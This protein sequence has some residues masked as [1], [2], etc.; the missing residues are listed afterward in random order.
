MLSHL[1]EGYNKSAKKAFGLKVR[2]RKKGVSLPKD[3]VSKIQ[4]KNYLSRALHNASSS[5]TP[6][7][8]QKLQLDLDVLK[9]EIRDCIS[10]HK[11]RKRQHLRS[12]LLRAD[13]SRKRFWRFLKS[14][15]KAAGQ[16]SAVYKVCDHWCKF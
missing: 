15:I 10:D 16:I 1:A 4:A 5:Q 3:I 14:Q 9:Q 7:E 13:P 11:I 12:K 8:V 6:Q 2:R